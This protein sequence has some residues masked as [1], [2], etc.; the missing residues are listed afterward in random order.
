MVRAQEFQ[1]LHL[2]IQVHF[3][4]DVGI[5]GTQGLD[6]RVA[7]SGF[8]NVLRT[9]YRGFGGHDLT[10]ELLFPL[11]QLIQVAVKGI[12]RHIGVDVHLGILIALTD[13]TSLPLLQ[14]RGPPGTI[15]MV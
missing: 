15:H 6:F 3:L 11:H 10:D 2:N 4:L 12:F 8:I 7:Q 14:I 5:A 13:N 9:A 1:L